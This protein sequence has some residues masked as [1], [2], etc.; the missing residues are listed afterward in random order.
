MLLRFY[1]AIAVCACSLVLAAGQPNVTALSIRQGKVRL[2]LPDGRVVLDGVPFVA[3]WQWFVNGGIDRPAEDQTLGP[4]LLRSWTGS[5]MYCRHERGSYQMTFSRLDSGDFSVAVTI[6]VSGDR[7]LNHWA[8]A[9]PPFADEQNPVVAKSVVDEWEQGTGAGENKYWGH[10]TWKRIT[11]SYVV[12]DPPGQSGWG[13]GATLDQR[14][15]TCL[16]LAHHEW[17]AWP[18]GQRY[19]TVYQRQPIFSGQTFTTR[20][21]F[22]V[23][24]DTDWR[25]LLRPHKDSL[26]RRYGKASSNYPPLDSRPVLAYYPADPTRI[27]PLDP[28]G[29]GNSF[30]RQPFME[31]QAAVLQKSQVKNVQGVHFWSFAAFPGEEWYQYDSRDLPEAAD[32]D[33]AGMV[34]DL[35]Q[36]GRKCGWTMRPE[37]A[38]VWT[39]S[40]RYCV[41]PDDP[42]WLPRLLE[43]F[44]TFGYVDTAGVGS[45]AQ[46]Y[47]G[48]ETRLF[49][50]LRKKH[51]PTAIWFPEFPTDELAMLTPG[52]FQVEGAGP[53]PDPAAMPTVW[54]GP[55]FQPHSQTEKIRWL[56][57]GR[58]WGLLDCG[59]WTG[60][61]PMRKAN[62]A[63]LGLTL[64]LH[65]FYDQ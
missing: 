9:L 47:Y 57:D 63:A 36:C 13:L 21:V 34:L 40:G 7:P 56:T 24:Q 23:S 62:A 53:Y 25:N 15:A 27:S 41:G 37:R 50:E 58:W 54:F 43:R 60:D 8:I 45:Q 46:P 2:A 26:E 11:G 39:R 12:F 5:T 16:W 49:H 52:Y 64:K 1:A 38:V 29:N 6:A 65:G 48:H 18:Q 14:Y 35:A 44:P 31:Y 4:L 20:V 55:L 3:D 32:K 19:L 30:G 22:R 17:T 42:R 51:G 61:L 28:L 33:A 59:N 10:R